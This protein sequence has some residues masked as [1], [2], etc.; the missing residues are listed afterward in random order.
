MTS[1]SVPSQ[2]YVQ[3]AYVSEQGKDF[4]VYR[5]AMASASG[6]SA[7]GGREETMDADQDS[8]PNLLA[9]Q[10]TDRK[11][12]SLDPTLVDSLAE[13]ILN[14]L[15]TGEKQER[16]IKLIADHL[17]E[18][19]LKVLV[20]KKHYAPAKSILVSSFLTPPMPITNIC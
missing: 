15:F 11:A 6:L 2:S 19:I 3:H 5:P 18:E 12:A 16:T 8:E 13:S 4:A 10:T 7:S 14:K 1:T 9:N 20:E 17:V